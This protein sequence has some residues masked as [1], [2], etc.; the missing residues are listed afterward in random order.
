V[1][2]AVRR[3]AVTAVSGRDADRCGRGASADVGWLD[4][5]AG[6]ADVAAVTG[7][8]REALR[9][10]GVRV[11]ENS[12]LRGIARSGHTWR[13]ATDAGPVESDVLGKAGGAVS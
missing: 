12:A 13:V 8:L 2:R 11:L 3:A 4:V 7:A 6:V 5:D 1:H 10:R 9:I